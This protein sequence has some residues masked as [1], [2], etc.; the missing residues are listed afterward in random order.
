MPFVVQLVL[1]III[2]I[3]TAAIFNLQQGE[4]IFQ[5]ATAIAFSV[6]T[7]ITLFISRLGSGSAKPGAKKPAKPA[8]KAGKG[9]EEGTVKWFNASKGF[10][11]ITRDNGEDIFVHQRSLADSNRRSLRQGQR[12]SFG[13]VDSEK[14]PQAAD[15]DVVGGG[16]ADDNNQGRNRRGPRNRNR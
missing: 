11:F 9:N 13:I 14:G 12:V 1:A 4:A 3:A 8:K 10:G 2:A 5:P 6:A 16:E 15:V 7:L